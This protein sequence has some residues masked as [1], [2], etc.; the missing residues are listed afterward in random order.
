MGSLRIVGSLGRLVFI[1]DW[2]G[3]C[4]SDLGDGFLSGRVGHRCWCGNLLVSGIEGG[5]Q[6][7][8]LC[9]TVLAI[10]WY[11]GS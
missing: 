10:C 11:F 1:I 9:C 4:L 5:K 2:I 6:G 7:D 8:V 3:G